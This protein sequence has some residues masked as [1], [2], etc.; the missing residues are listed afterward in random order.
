MLADDIGILLRCVSMSG[1]RVLVSHRHSL[2]NSVEGRVDLHDLLFD[3][4]LSFGHQL[5]LRAAGG[6]FILWGLLNHLN[7]N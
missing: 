5:G 6:F 1:Q 4:V 7:M 3:D 2:L